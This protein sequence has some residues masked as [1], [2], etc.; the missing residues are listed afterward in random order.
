MKIILLSGGSGKRL[1]PLSNDSRSKQFLKVLKA[2]DGKHESMVQRVVRQIHENIPDAEIIIATS[3][4]QK[5]VITSQ[6]GD[7]V[8]VV[9]EPMRR[10][11]FPAIALSCA[12]LGY[13]K[14]CDP[15][16]VVAVLPCDQFTESTYFQ[17]VR[18]M[19][20][21]A[22]GKQDLTLMG[23][24]PE[25]PSSNFGYILPEST[26]TVPMTVKTF[27]EKPKEDR[28]RE[29]IEQGGFW[30]GGVFAF[31]LGY[32][33]DKVAQYISDKDFQKVYDRYEDFPKISFDY[34][35]VEKANSI[36]MLP[37]KGLWKDLGSWDALSGQM[38]IENNNCILSECTNT[39]VANELAIPVVCTGTKD[40]V[41]AASLDG[42]L[43]TAP[44]N[45]AR[46]KE[47]VSQLNL[48][49]MYEERRW[50]EFRVV[51]S[52][53][54]AD[55]LKSL[56]KRLTLWAGKNISYQIHHHRSEVW[57]VVRGKGILILDGE[58]R[59]ITPGQTVHIEK[60]Q[61]HAIKAVTDLEIIEVQIGDLLTEEDIIRFDWPV[62]N[63]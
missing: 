9:V 53:N 56:T 7:Q 26:D 40:I 52:T 35:V 12:Y 62:S 47:A 3:A 39:Y 29:I 36:A 59:E 2:P 14:G 63:I 24:Y 1:W 42:I 20:E 37:F 8:T 19:G 60:G 33:L 58:V 11:T 16:E 49:P 15:D 51:D 28:A 43:V 27:V 17:V 5:D 57:T 32:V 55:G 30:N 6:L 48:R 18:Q 25:S 61:K 45:A 44:D 13:E 34:E 46:L 23:V 50:G 21:A 4:N 54:D 10:D 38:D 41:V 22:R 31:R